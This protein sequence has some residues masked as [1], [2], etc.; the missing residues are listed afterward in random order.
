[1][2]F[3]QK[4]YQ[5]YRPINNCYCKYI[6]PFQ[7]NIH[8]VILMHPKEARRQKTGTGRLTHLALENSEIIVDIDFTNNT[9]V[10]ELLNNPNQFS[11]LLY[12]GNK[13]QDIVENNVLPK[14]TSQLQTNI[15][16]LDATWFCAK[17]MLNRSAN[18]QKMPFISFNSTEKSQFLFKKQPQSY[19]LSTIEATYYLIKLCN[20]IGVEQTFNMEKN[21]L[22]VLKK[23]VDFQ[24][25]NQKKGL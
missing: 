17:Q 2:V 6:K 23:L 19:C 25:E 22:D 15:F 21:L 13:S 3:R 16:L 9:R 10:N 8:F 20:Q 11:A 4:C 7:T 5:C 14:P 1:M 18:L 12:P 24:I